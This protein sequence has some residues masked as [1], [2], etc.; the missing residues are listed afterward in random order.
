MYQLSKNLS[1]PKIVDHLRRFL[2]DEHPLKDIKDLDELAELLQLSA[3]LEY[4]D[5]YFQVA[6]TILKQIEFFPFPKLHNQIVT[7]DTLEDYHFVTLKAADES[8]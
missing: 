1:S 6:M 4:D 8:R 7:E 3:C 2:Q 5:M